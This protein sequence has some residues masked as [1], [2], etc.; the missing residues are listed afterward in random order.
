MIREKNIIALVVYRDGRP[1]DDETQV[2]SPE[3]VFAAG[4]ASAKIVAADLASTA[5]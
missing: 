3:Q 4:F 5:R 1:R 2:T